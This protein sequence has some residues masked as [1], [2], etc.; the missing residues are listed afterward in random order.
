MTDGCYVSEEVRAVERLHAG[1]LG[2]GFNALPIRAQLN[3]Q[4]RNI[5]AAHGN[6]DGAIAMQVKSWLPRAARLS[7]AEILRVPLDLADARLA[8]AREYGFAAWDAVE[9]LGDA[10]P[11]L[12]FEEAVDALVAGD[13]AGL[14][15]RLDGAPDLVRARSA[16][17][18]RAT[19]LHYAAANGVESY[20]QKTPYR[21]VE[22][23]A[24]LLQRG[25][26]ADATAPIYGGAQ[27]TY[28]LVMTSAHPKAAGVQEALGRL[29]RDG[30]DK[31]GHQ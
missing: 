26:D 28:D 2:P 29:L 13:I 6:G 5:V 15:R 23:A 30:R 31:P 10:R 19:L 16:Y 20:R 24:L 25:A 8:M 12:A 7:T 18:H 17:G 11:D 3:G 4:A 27:T 1:L 22:I 14:T 9:A 21:I